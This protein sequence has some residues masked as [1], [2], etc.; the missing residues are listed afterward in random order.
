MP[1]ETPS[2]FDA[3][4]QENGQ[5]DDALLRPQE[6]I[7]RGDRHEDE[8]D[9][10]QHLVEMASP[11]KMPV[12]Q[13]FEHEPEKGGGEEGER[14]RREERHTKPF[15]EDDRDIAARHGEDAMGEVHEVHEAKRHR[16]PAGEYEKQ[17]AV[18]DA[19]EE[20]RQHEPRSVSFRSGAWPRAR[21]VR[22]NRLGLRS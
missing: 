10:E 17:H 19:I 6:V 5:L 9:R 16:E 4:L 11:V 1:M 2:P 8:A 7:R 20:D 13:P 21:S 14:K 18:G 12:E 15:H 3:R 22:W